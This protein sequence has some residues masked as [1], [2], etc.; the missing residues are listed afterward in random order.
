MQNI[1]LH[2]TTNDNW[3]LEKNYEQTTHTAV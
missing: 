1:K 2:C 3:L